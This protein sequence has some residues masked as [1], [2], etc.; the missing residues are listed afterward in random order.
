MPGFSMAGTVEDRLFRRELGNI[1]SSYV[2]P[3]GIYGSKSFVQDL[4]IINELNGHSGCVNALSWSKSGRL[5]ASGSDD[6]VINIYSYLPDYANAQFDLSTQIDTGHTRNIFSVKFMP[7]SNDRTIVSAAGDAQIRVFDIER[8]AVFDGTRARLSQN[9][10]NCKVFRSHSAAVKRIVTEA[11]P[12]Y[13]L[14]CAEDGD[15]RQ[16]DI[17]Q[18]ESAY[19]RSASRYYVNRHGRSKDHAPPPLISYGDYNIDLMTISCSPSQPHYIALGGTALH[20]FLHD[21]RMTGRD[22]FNER[23]STPADENE[24]AE[25]TRCVRKFAPYGQPKM[26]RSDPKSIT[27]CKI[28]DNNPNELIVSWNGDFIYS[29]DIMR[30]YQNPEGHQGFSSG[31]RGSRA[32]H[33]DRKR[34]R[35]EASTSG[36]SQLGE[37]RGSSHPR[38]ESGTSGDRQE[39]S[40]LL[41]MEGGESVEIPLTGRAFSGSR[42]TRSQPR[43]R[44]QGEEIAQQ[45]RQVRNM[46]FNVSQTTHSFFQPDTE[47]DE[48]TVVRNRLDQVLSTSLK[49]LEQVDKLINQWTYPITESSNQIAFQNKLREDRAKTW[50]FVQACGTIAR[51]ASRKPTATCPRRVLELF[52]M[53]KPAPR[54]SAMP[55]ERHEQFGYDFIKTVLLWLDSGV[56][57]VL[58]GFTHDPDDPN[59]SYKRRH[60][61]SLDADVD[62]IDL[63]LIP[64]L[65]RL[66]S[67]NAVDDLDD[68]SQQGYI[69]R[70]EVDAVNSLSR[71]MRIPFAD[72]AGRSAEMDGQGRALTQDRET[73]VKFWAYRVCRAVLKNAAIDVTYSLVDTAFGEFVDM[74][75]RE[76]ETGT[77]GSSA[78]VTEEDEEEVAHE[79]EN[80]GDGN[81]L[82]ADESSDNDEGSSD[83][84][85]DEDDD[86]DNDEESPFLLGGPRTARSKMTAG[87]NVPCLTHTNR[88]VGHCNVETTKDVNFYGLQDEY[89]ISGSDCGNFFIWDKKSTK[90]LN[91]LEGDNEVVNVVQGH[92]YEPMIAVSGIDSTVKIFGVDARARKDAALGI[93]IEEVDRSRFSSIG[94]RGRRERLRRQRDRLADEEVQRNQMPNSAFDLPDEPATT[95]KSPLITSEPA[96]PPQQ[97]DDAEPP[98]YED[99]EL[100]KSKHGL[101]SRRRIQDEDRI[102][103]TNDMDRRRGARQGGFITRSM[104]AMLAQHM[105]AHAGGGDDEGEDVDPENC[106]VM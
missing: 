31:A 62:A 79:N 10:A 1:T 50:R 94:L 68:D 8:A 61:V 84:E 80:I 18:P 76:H 75:N 12:F 5:L 24:L 88:Y 105:R 93:G 26:R 98:W 39:L 45:V 52:D 35:K 23:G 74:S 104:L 77:D 16:W 9:Q 92:P 13:F 19:P 65:H 78:V 27:A 83:D 89:V 2:K 28:S 7:H 106:A 90:L 59:M 56:G 64:Y 82:N 96:L 63:E 43:E 11:S 34:K 25:A 87:K 54:E 36:L 66:A 100:I 44:S 53:I 72:L 69:F 38:T 42:L 46:L 95:S 101:Q 3:R 33:R 47:P 86:D 103:S 55:L 29:F 14:S 6:R 58:R 37:A 15:V 51:V 85:D 21:R 71:A 81:V 60:P 48:P 22:K 67:E 49:L 40:L 99:E 57:A 102:V 20:C 32:K 91:I 41:Q 70:T 73:A 17:R 97:D 4:D 30:D